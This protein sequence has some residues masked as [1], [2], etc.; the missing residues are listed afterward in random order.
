MTFDLKRYRDQLAQLVAQPSVSCAD[1]HWDMGNK[2]V[3]DLLS[4]W[5]DARGF[6]CELLP[7]PGKNGK[8]NL[9]ASK[10]TGPGG[11]VF[12]GHSDTVPYDDNRW[13]SDPFTL[14]GWQAVRPGRHRYEGLFPG[15]AGGD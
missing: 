15:G 4:E 14:T 13:Q 7:V 3:L 10:G 2:P 11:L 12:S 9:I 1:P 6:E 5:L 8:Y